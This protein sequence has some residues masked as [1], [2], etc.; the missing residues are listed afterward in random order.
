[1]FTHGSQA[2]L[3]EQ[4]PAIAFG[5]LVNIIVYAIFAVIGVRLFGQQEE[6]YPSGFN[7]GRQTR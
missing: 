7:A 5:L 2:P 4:L 3:R 6:T 1:M